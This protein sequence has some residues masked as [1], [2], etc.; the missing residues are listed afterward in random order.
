MYPGTFASTTP[1]KPAVIMAGSEEQLTYAELEAR[2]AQL[3]QLFAA[4]GLERGDHVSIF[5]ENNV[6]FFECFWAAIRSGL[7]F[8]TINRYL[9]PEETAYILQDSGAK[10]LITSAAMAELISPVPPLAP[11][12]EVLLSVD[13]PVEG[14]ARYE[15]E[16]TAFPAERLPTNPGAKRCSTAPARRVGQRASSV[17]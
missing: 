10:A 14:F 6:R 9:Q 13:G 15:D 12:V 8:T 1:D 5:M 7:Y 16:I 3:A 17:H 11:D 2:S 4:A